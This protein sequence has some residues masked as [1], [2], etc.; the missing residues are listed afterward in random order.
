MTNRRQFLKGVAALSSLSLAGCGWRLAEVRANS[1]TSS[2]RN[3]L[4]I[5]TW[6][7]YTD[8]K[9]LRTF[10]TQTGMKVLADVYDSNDVMLAK[11]Q[12]GGGG[13]YSIIYPSDYMVQKMVNKGLLT[14]INHDRLIGLENLFPRFQNPSYDPN[15]RYSIPFNWGTTGFLYNSEKIK[16]VPQDWDYLWQNQEELN[17]RMTLLNDVREVMGA[18]LRMLGYSYNSKNEQEI[19]QAYEKLKVLKPAIA[20]FDTDAW[21]NQ[22]LA[23][24]L[25]LAMCYS[26]D[27]VKISQENPKLKYVIPRSGSSLWTDTIVIPKASPNLDGAYAWI[28]MILQPKIAAQIS[29]RLSVSTPNKAGFEQLPKIIQNNGNL[30]PSESLLANCERVTPVGDFEEV[31]DRYWTQLTSS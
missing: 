21:Q 18:T 27:A 1:N 8:Q 20:R 28:N 11:L 30:F 7:Q 15:N 23:G 4:Y 16:D 14:E 31:Y 5:F 19:K 6:T 17:Q 26:A 25:L 29:K 3:Q 22:I 9:L 24:D 12:A 13:T 2:Q 10:N